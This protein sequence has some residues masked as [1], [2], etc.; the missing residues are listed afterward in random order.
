MGTGKLRDLSN[1]DVEGNQMATCYL[2][3]DFIYSEE[4][5]KYATGLS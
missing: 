3:Y 4:V 2:K 1:Y 5:I